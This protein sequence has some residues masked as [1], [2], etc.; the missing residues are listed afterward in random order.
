MLRGCAQR[1]LW[2]LV[3][4]LVL[5]G[6]QLAGLPGR[7]AAAHHAALGHAMAI[8]AAGA[9]GGTPSPCQ[10]DEPHGMPCCQASACTTVV[11]PPQMAPALTLPV[12]RSVV[13]FLPPAPRQTG[14]TTPDPALRPPR[15]AI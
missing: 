2:G 15:A 1:W 8:A 5:G 11:A 9:S 6:M 4:L 10:P 7:A 13:A 14:G 3:A 12:A